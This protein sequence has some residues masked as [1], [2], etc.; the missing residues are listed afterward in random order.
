MSA[1]PS[2][3]PSYCRHKATG[4]AV[5][6]LNGRDHYLGLYGSPESHERYARLIA[7]WQTTGNSS[8]H[9]AAVAAPSP[10]ELSINEVLVRYVEFAR[11]YYTKDGKPNQ[12]FESLRYAMRRLK[13]LFGHSRAADFGPKDLKLNP[14]IRTIIAARQRV[15]AA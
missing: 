1:S 11:T 2:K 7:Q 4:Q 10:A 9:R 3:V 8:P 5:V 13:E 12:E 14:S 6:R 15:P